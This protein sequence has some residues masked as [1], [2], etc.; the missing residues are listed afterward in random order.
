VTPQNDNSATGPLEQQLLEATAH[1]SAETGMLDS[2]TAELRESWLALT[3]L[4]QD[5]D[6]HLEQRPIVVKPGGRTRA[7]LVKRI[8]AVAV[9]ASLLIGL[10]VCG[11]L[12]TRGLRV[13][14]ADS[15]RK[16]AAELESPQ[17]PEVASVQYGWNDEEFDDAIRLTGDE[18]LRVQQEWY[19]STGP[20]GLLSEQFGEFA[21]DL[22]GDSL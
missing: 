17:A 9:A 5:R 22:S 21:D 8:T 20:Y 14:P 11:F 1:P 13:A 19:I 15:A 10:G 18:M 16:R 3:N 6:E 2:E 12:F 4:L 7:N